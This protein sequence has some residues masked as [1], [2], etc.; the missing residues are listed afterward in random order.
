MAYTP[1]TKATFIAIFPSFA[2]VSDEAYDFWSGQAVLIT[3][4]LQD[5]LAGQMDLA[6]M[7]ATAW[8]LTDAG[9]GTGA[10]S[11]MAAQGASGFKRIKSGT[12]ELERGDATK[13]ESAGVYG[14]NSYGVA[15]F[16]MIRPC[17]AGPR[18]TGTGC[19][20]CGTGF[21]GWAGPLPYGRC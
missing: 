5:C 21:N 10:E 18:V 1:P 2:A 19:V 12:I 8:Y 16:A 13:A 3:E 7:R 20:P 17:L 14:S 9:I 4:P 6:T 11:E 15:F